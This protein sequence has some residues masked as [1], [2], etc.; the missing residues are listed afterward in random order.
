GVVLP[1]SGEDA[2]SGNELLQGVDLAKRQLQ[3]KTSTFDYR[4][5]VVV[6]NDDST[7]DGAKKA[8]LQIAADPRIV[9]VVGHFSSADTLAA[10]PIYKV[11][12]LPVIMPIATLTSITS[13]G[14][15]PNA[16]RLPPTND[17]QAQTVVGFAVDYLP[18]KSIF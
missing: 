11:A 15:F 6:F 12:K 3:E 8:A 13:E 5:E 17:E 4:V 2:V 18:G 1:L 14:R 10:L 9:A 7:E 16:F